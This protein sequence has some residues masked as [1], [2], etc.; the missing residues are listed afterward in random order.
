MP[1]EIFIK[2]IIQNKA[3]P[4]LISLLSFQYFG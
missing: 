3:N 4:T 1:P 2:L